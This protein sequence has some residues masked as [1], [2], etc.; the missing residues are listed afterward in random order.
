[1]AV[2][3][4]EQHPNSCSPTGGYLLSAA[5]C[6][7]G[8]GRSGAVAAA[9]LAEMGHS[10]HAVDIDAER[11]TQLST[12]KAPFFEPGLDDLLSHNLKAGRLSFTTAWSEA[13]PKAEGVL[14]CVPTPAGGDGNA[15]LSFL[16]SALNDV[17]PLLTPG[18][19]VI[20]RSTVP[21]GTNASIGRR[22]RSERP[23]LDAAVVSNPE[24]LREGHAVDDFLRPE[25]V[26]I[27]SAGEDA[28][29]RAAALFLSLTCP[30][31]LMDL[32]TAE[33]TKYAANAY[34]ATSISFINEIANICE[35]TGADASLVRQALKLDQ[36]IGDN[37]YI[38]P[39][40]GFGGSCLPKDISALVRTAEEHGYD[41]TLLK[42]V[43]DVN[44]L[45]PER[46]AGHII[47]LF[48]DLSSRKIAVLGISFKGDTFDVR[49]SPAMAVIRDLKELGVRVHA[50]DPMADATAK[51]CVAGLADLHHDA[52]DTVSDCDA[53]VVATEHSSFRDLDLKRLG[54]AMASRVLIDGRNLFEPKTVTEAGFSYIGIGRARRGD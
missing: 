36:R 3:G 44:A 46:V 39:G 40:I 42:A 16:D 33:V 35:R 43:I 19:L 28:G 54:E 13:V 18:A 26:V 38:D 34:L 6:V 9:G 5:L 14:L 30:I 47:D 12:G 21:I 22:I 2:P 20:T 1:M 24:F 25:R 45:Q 41:P 37:A 49:S 29:E 31:L 27:G 4:I 52:Y 53:V 32:E 51:A 10:V 7:V 15:D 23:D 8:A 48:S 11:V 50:Y 17:I